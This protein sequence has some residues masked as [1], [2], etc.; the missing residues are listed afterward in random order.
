LSMSRTTS[1]TWGTPLMNAFPNVMIILS[2]R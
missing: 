2:L 1:A